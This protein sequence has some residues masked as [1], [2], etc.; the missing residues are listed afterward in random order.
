MSIFSDV[1]GLMSGGS[2]PDAAKG[3]IG[4]ELSNVLQGQGIGGIS[5]LIQ[6]F[7][8]SGM[9]AQASSWVGNGANQPVSVSHIEQALGPSV[10]S[11]IASRFGMDPQQ[12]TQML[13]QH[14]PGIVDHMTPN[15]ALP[16]ESSSSNAAAD[17]DPPDDT[18]SDNTDTSDDDK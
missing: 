12:A 11:A 10:I 9:G 13:S 18:D 7:E 4:S 2:M 16:D 1:S 3:N 17:N 5:G 6:K 14:L 8:Q 15:G